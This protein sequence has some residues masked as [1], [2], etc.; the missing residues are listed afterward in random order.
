[1]VETIS[2]G[3]SHDGVTEFAARR[4]LARLLEKILFELGDIDRHVARLPSPKRRTGAG[5][6]AQEKKGILNANTGLGRS[7]WLPTDTGIVRALLEPNQSR[8]SM[9]YG[10]D[11]PHLETVHVESV[12]RLFLWRNAVE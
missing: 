12:E 3:Q 5:R 9:A 7:S 4:A 8:K 2:A 6:L 1:L 10:W 11:F